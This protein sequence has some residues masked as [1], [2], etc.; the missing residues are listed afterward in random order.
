MKRPRP[1]PPSLL[2]PPL[3]PTQT[4]PQPQLSTAALGGWV[5]VVSGPSSLTLSPVGT[6]TIYAASPVDSVPPAYAP[7]PHTHNPH[8]MKSESANGGGV[9][10]RRRRRRSTTTGN[11]DESVILV[12]GSGA[13]SVTSSG[14][15]GDNDSSE[16]GSPTAEH[17]HKKK[18]KRNKPTLSCFECVGRKT[19][20]RCI[21]LFL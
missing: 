4:Q 11:G 12:G 1:V 18:Q 16:N 15:G 6:S 19:K 17:P 13:G 10:T 5:S 8:I 9:G 2:P 14:L 3:P 21:R 20:V 7:I